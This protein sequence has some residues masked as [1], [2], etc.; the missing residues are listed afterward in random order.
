MIPK[1]FLVYF[2]GNRRK[3]IEA[4]ALKE[5]APK[6]I[7]KYLKRFN[8]GQSNLGADNQKASVAVQ[9]NAEN[10][11]IHIETQRDSSTDS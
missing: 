3:R 9:G 7:Q 1:I 4:L 11:E 2:D 5:K 8:D 6:I 10:I